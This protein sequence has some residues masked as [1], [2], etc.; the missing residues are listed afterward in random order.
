MNEKFYEIFRPRPS[1]QVCKL[2][3][4]IVKIFIFSSNLV[5]RSW[6]SILLKPKYY[7]PVVTKAGSS[8]TKI[9]GPALQ[10]PVDAK[11]FPEGI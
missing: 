10:S 4:V 8:K 7:S 11:E 6:F 1:L 2:K 5:V 9:L 3:F